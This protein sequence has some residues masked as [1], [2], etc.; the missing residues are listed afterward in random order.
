MF[1][2]KTFLLHD[3]RPTF[4]LV[5]SLVPLVKDKLGDL[6][7]SDNYR[8]IAIS[9][10]FLKIFDWV[11]ILLY[12]DQ[13]STSDLQFGFQEKSS[14]T[15]CTCLLKE[16]VSYC[17]NAENTAEASSRISMQELSLIRLG[18]LPRDSKSGTW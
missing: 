15:M 12:G 5:C 2:F 11:V 9:S 18:Q 16:V 3:Y 7:N 10:I 4:L 13:I 8:A 1:L 6:S 17:A 14:T